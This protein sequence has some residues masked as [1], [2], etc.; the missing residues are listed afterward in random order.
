MGTAGWLTA[1][2]GRSGGATDVQGPSAQQQL[3]CQTREDPRV[4][5]LDH[6]SFVCSSS[7]PAAPRSEPPRA[8]QSHK[9]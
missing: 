9:L 1:Q 6:T 5:G 8:G 7:W 2:P 4:L 3:V